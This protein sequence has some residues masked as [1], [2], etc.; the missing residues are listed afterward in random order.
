M[1][2][3]L[4]TRGARHLVVPSRSGATSQAAVETLHQLK[5][6]AI[7]VLTPVCDVAS[8]DS[9]SRMLDECGKTMPPVRGCIVATMALNVSVHTP[10]YAARFI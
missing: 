8:A 2:K 1:L 5:A 10:S 3:W 4:A 9:L 6:Q 7:T